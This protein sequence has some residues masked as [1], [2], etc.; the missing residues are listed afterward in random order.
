MLVF[1]N[2]NFLWYTCLFY[3]AAHEN[4]LKPPNIKFER[5]KQLRYKEPRCKEFRETI[6]QTSTE[7]LRR[8]QPITSSHNANIYNSS[9]VQTTTIITIARV[10][11]E[12]QV[13]SRTKYCRYFATRVR[14]GIK[15]SSTLGKFPM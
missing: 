6:T 7:V 1:F 2:K 9:L 13:V 11:Y 10:N 8:Q 14:D 4:F 12:I 3:Y 5:C 15:R